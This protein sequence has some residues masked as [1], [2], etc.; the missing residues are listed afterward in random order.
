M[1]GSRLPIFGLYGEYLNSEK[2]LIAHLRRA[3]GCGLLIRNLE[4]LPEKVRVRFP[5]LIANAS[6][7]RVL[8]TTRSFRSLGENLGVFQKHL[9]IPPLEHRPEDIRLIIST[10]LWKRGHFT[11]TSEAMEVFLTVRW[12]GEFSELADCVMQSLW[13][14][15]EHGRSYIDKTDVLAVRGEAAGL[16]FWFLE[17]FLGSPFRYRI[18]QQ[19]LRNFLR[20]FEAVVIASGLLETCGNLTRTA[21]HFR[22]PVNTL[23]GRCKSLGTLLSEAQTM[24]TSKIDSAGP[25]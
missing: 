22:V 24:L 15:R 21:Q 13:R 12:P 11:C 23:I 25:R 1:T 3:K 9:S 2:E 17:H 10:L 18:E 6:D 5:Q 14:A 7:V 19:G 4:K 8:A 16:D 20:E